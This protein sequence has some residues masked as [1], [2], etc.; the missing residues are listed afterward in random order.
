M[1]R[2]GAAYTAGWFSPFTR[3]YVENW[4]KSQKSEGVLKIKCTAMK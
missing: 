3:S 4:E 2:F 1:A